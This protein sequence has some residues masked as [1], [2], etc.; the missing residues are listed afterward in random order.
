MKTSPC[1]L[2]IGCA[3]LLTLAG[4]GAESFAQTKDQAAAAMDKMSEKGDG[5][6]SNLGEQLS[7][8]MEPGDDE[9]LSGLAEELGTHVAKLGESLKTNPELTSQLNSAVQS[10]LK[11]ND[12]DAVGALNGLS[13]ASLTPSQKSLLK[14]TYDTAAAYVTDRNFSSLEGFEGE[15]DQIVSALRGGDYKTA[16]QPLQKIWGQAELSTKQKEL[17][18]GVFDKYAP[19]WRGAADSLNKGLDAVKGLGL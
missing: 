18:S 17:L 8:S 15:V 4:G 7:A 3:L 16:I 14:G 9:M 5:A 1:F 19:G 13:E 11:N 6:F 12:V 10:L 2:P